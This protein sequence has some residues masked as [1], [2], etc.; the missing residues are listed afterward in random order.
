MPT[1]PRP[2]ETEETEE[3]LQTLG[4]FHLEK[5]LGEGGMGA[6]YRA[7]QISMEAVMTGLAH[8][9]ETLAGTVGIGSMAAQRA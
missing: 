4:D 2:S 5:K 9:R 1:R 7:H 6:V 8:K 3:A